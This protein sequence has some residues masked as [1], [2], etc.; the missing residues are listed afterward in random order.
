MLFLSYKIW[1]VFSNSCCLLQMQC[2]RCGVLFEL[3]TWHTHFHTS[4]I[5]VHTSLICIHTS[6]TY[7]CKQRKCTHLGRLF[8]SFRGYDITVHYFEV[9]DRRHA[10]KG[11]HARS[12]LREVGAFILHNH[13]HW[14]LLFG[15]NW[16]RFANFD[17][18]CSS[19][20]GSFIFSKFRIFIFHIPY[21]F[22][23]LLF[24][25]F[26]PLLAFI[27]MILKFIFVLVLHL[28]SSLITYHF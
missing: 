23:N 16:F 20:F 28:M 8:D 6:H 13:L 11:S 18:F 2:L 12:H 3:Y 17:I 24:F 9:Y 19:I 14:N 10:P 27:F 7:C 1:G 5:C 21:R 22:S 26:H 4:L 15:C 25:L